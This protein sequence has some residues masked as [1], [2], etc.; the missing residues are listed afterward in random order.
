M[1]AS[2]QFHAPAALTPGKA[3]STH[4]IGGWEGPRAV[5]DTVVKRKFPSP[6]RESNSRTP[7]TQPVAQRYADWAI[8]ALYWAN[9]LLNKF[10]QAKENLVKYDISRSG[11]QCFGKRHENSSANATPTKTHKKPGTYFLIIVVYMHCV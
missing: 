2:G 11:S 5:L 9:I 8:T 7:I 10:K 1:E 6:R 3:R 4:Y